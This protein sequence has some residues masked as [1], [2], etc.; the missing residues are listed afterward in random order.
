MIDSFKGICIFA[1]GRSGST[2]LCEQL[3][4][5]LRVKHQLNT[6]SLYEILTPHC[7]LT[8][9]FKELAVD[10][11]GLNERPFRTSLDL[12]R[13]ERV[14]D[15]ISSDIFPIFK[16]FSSDMTHDNKDV[17]DRIIVN[18][19]NIF[20]ISLNRADVVNQYLSWMISCVTGVW[21]HYD[22]DDPNHTI[23]KNNGYSNDRSIP[24]SNKHNA[25]LNYAKY[26]AS[27]VLLHYM[28]HF[29]VGY[30]KCNQTVWYDQL[31][32]TDYPE[33]G[34]SKTDLIESQLKMNESHIETLHQCFKNADEIIDI[35]KRLESSIKPMLDIL[36]PD[37][38]HNRT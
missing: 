24:P 31:F 35:A 29:E 19:S 5:A 3:A 38:N 9:D 2:L 37:L 28:W 8:P 14:E 17:M 4:N 36:R 16:I 20:K 26:I 25:D 10:M 13:L 27:G 15:I 1:Y 6:K 22:F 18:N 11:T 7:V 30:R 23:D 21:H 32:N 34:I 33:L 12:Y